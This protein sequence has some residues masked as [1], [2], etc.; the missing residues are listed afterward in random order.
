MPTSVL[1]SKE[2]KDLLSTYPMSGTNYISVHVTTIFQF[3]LQPQVL[4]Q[5][6]SLTICQFKNKK[7][8]LFENNTIICITSSV[9][10]VE[11]LKMYRGSQVVEL[12][13]SS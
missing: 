3:I 4:P 8:D 1:F 11:D 10:R 6:I 2:P 12:T 9:W 7:S 5:Y 13:W